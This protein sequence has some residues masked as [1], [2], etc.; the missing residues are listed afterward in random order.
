M[1]RG[2]HVGDEQLVFPGPRPALH[3]VRVERAARPDRDGS[4]I[5]LTPG[6]DVHPG[7]MRVPERHS[8]P[9]GAPFIRHLAA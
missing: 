9:G 3:P 7:S 8:E 5:P 1:P 6:P 4:A 2:H